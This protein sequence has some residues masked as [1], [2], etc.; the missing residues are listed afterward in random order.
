[1]LK[2]KVKHTTLKE[3]WFVFVNYPLSTPREGMRR[4]LQYNQT[5]VVRPEKLQRFKILTG[6]K[7]PL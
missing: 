7:L 2:W 5:I 6:A 4:A 1:M 3:E